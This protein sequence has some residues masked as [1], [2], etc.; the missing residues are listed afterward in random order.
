MNFDFRSIYCLCVY[1]DSFA[2]WNDLAQISDRNVEKE[3]LLRLFIAYRC[4]EKYC[5][6]T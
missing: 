1:N 6:Q 5:K 2:M 4:L 3:K